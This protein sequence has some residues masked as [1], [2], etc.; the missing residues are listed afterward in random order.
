[1]SEKTKTAESS[2][3]EILDL[4]ITV[5]KERKDQRSLTTATTPRRRSAPATFFKNSNKKTAAETYQSLDRNNRIRLLLE[6]VEKETQDI[7]LFDAE[8]KTSIARNISCKLDN[9][10]LLERVRS[11]CTV[12]SPPTKRHGLGSSLELFHDDL[13]NDGDDDDDDYSVLSFDEEGSFTDYDEDGSMFDE[14]DFDDE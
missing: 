1:M 5:T 7:E 12:L 13:E 3:P 6:R 8:D 2:D 4:S 11:A 10:L 9:L 14:D